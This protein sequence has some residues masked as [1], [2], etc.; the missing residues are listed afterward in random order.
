VPEESIDRYCFVVA[1][2]LVGD[3][4]ITVANEYVTYGERSQT[5]PISGKT[6]AI[7]VKLC[8]PRPSLSV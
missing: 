8:L 3:D 4:L 2:A 6:A 7:N 1:A 5:L